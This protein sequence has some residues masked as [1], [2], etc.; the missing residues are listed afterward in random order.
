M[1]PVIRVFVDGDFHDLLLN[2]MPFPPTQFHFKA[3]LYCDV[4]RRHVCV[5]YRIRDLHHVLEGS[6][7]EERPRLLG[8]HDK[9]TQHYSRKI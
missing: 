9:C 1:M 3:L 2:L 7:A 8:T 5:Q 6:D 4:F